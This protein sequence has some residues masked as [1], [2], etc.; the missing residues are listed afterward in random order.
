[1]K[2]I[3]KG[4]PTHK[5]CPNGF[6]PWEEMEPNSASGQKNHFQSIAHDIIFRVYSFEVSIQATEKLIGYFTYHLQELRLADYAAGY[7]NRDVFR[8][9]RPAPY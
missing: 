2:L 4:P 6:K 7:M 3:S 1:M 9:I 8:I 5:L